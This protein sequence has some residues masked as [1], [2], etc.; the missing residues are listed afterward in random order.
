M[1]GTWQHVHYQSKN[2]CTKPAL[3]A[4]HSCVSLGA[5]VCGTIIRALIG[6]L[7]SFSFSFSNYKGNRSVIGHYFF[8][9]SSRNLK[10]DMVRA[11]GIFITNI[12]FDVV[13]F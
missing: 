7:C 8:S 6:F 13:I 9:V 4:G 12:Q 1:M 2:R 10:C 11:G 5:S 3:G